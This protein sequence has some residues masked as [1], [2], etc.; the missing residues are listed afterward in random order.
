MSGLFLALSFIRE[1]P[2][3]N[4]N[5][6]DPDQTPRSVASDLGLHCLPVMGCHKCIYSL[7][8]GDIFRGNNTDIEMF[9]CTL[10]L[11]GGYSY[12]KE[13]VPFGSKFLRLS[14][15]SVFESI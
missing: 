13:F 1:I 10:C 11:I 9:K 6:V 2:A 12:R 5:S 7:E 8:N 15:T 4:T 14:A 3:L